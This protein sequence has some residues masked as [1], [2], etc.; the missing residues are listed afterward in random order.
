MEQNQE[1]RNKPTLIKSINLQHKRQEYTMEKRVFL[2]CGAG[3]L[4]S[5]VQKNELD[6]FLTP[7]TQRNTK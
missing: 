7:Y 4:D 6:Y 5:Y 1:P 3:K 2:I